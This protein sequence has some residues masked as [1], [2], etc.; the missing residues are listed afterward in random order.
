[1]A[2]KLVDEFS[3]YVPLNFTD[4]AGVLFAGSPITWSQ[5]GVENL[6]RA[7]GH[8]LEEVLNSNVDYPIVSLT[9][10]HKTVLGL[11]DSVRVRTEATRA[12]NKSITFETSVFNNE[13]ELAVRIT[14]VQVAV[15][16]ENRSRSVPLEDWIRALAR[17]S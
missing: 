6:F 2:K 16:T 10:E 9:I 13:G 1:M 4:A 12:G 8:P 14:Q 15:Q 3:M 5:M 17:P 11:G 7:A